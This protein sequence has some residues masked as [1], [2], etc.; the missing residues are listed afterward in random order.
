MTYKEA[1]DKS[2]EF[3]QKIVEA[4]QSKFSRPDVSELLTVGKVL[5]SVGMKYIHV[6]V[7]DEAK[8][9]FAREGV[10]QPKATEVPAK[11]GKQDGGR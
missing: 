3:L 4:V 10:K 5:F 8:E 6:V 1:Y 11:T 9:A 2:W 7:Y